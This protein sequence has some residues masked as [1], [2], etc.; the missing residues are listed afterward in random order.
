MIQKIKLVKT[1][2]GIA[3]LAL[4]IPDI[5]KLNYLFIDGLKEVTVRWHIRK[6]VMRRSVF[7]INSHSQWDK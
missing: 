4:R 1:Y 2:Y 7:L 5:L 3:L 6:G